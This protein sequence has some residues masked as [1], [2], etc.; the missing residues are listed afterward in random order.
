MKAHQMDIIIGMIQI[1]LMKNKI[2]IYYVIIFI[3]DFIFI[4]VLII[5]KI[6]YEFCVKISKITSIFKY[7]ENNYIIML[8]ELYIYLYNLEYLYYL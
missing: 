3:L 2:N 7:E 4:I 1:V 6:Y 5:S 8:F